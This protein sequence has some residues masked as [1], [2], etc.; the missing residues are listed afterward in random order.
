[1]MVEEQ[2][3]ARAGRLSSKPLFSLHMEGKEVIQRRSYWHNLF[4][5]TI[6]IMMLVGCSGA[7]QDQ[8]D[9][10]NIATDS[11]ISPTETLSPQTA[12]VV[13]PTATPTPIPPTLTPTSIPADQG[14]IICGE[15]EFQ[16]N[17]SSI[18]ED[19]SVSVD[20]RIFE[21]SGGTLFMPIVPD[22]NARTLIIDLQLISGNRESFYDYGFQV[23]NE[24]SELFEIKTIL[25]YETMISW[26]IPNLT[27]SNSFVVLCPNGETIDLT[28]IM[29]DLPAESW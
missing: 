4:T 22:M 5:L 26:I 20:A 1:M 25:V 9:I 8:A 10:A 15:Y 29:E 24:D 28:P 3:K 14:P 16:L 17:N 18:L 23:I 13:P 7:L 21:G 12:T 11:H 19:F 27:P 6:S 2:T